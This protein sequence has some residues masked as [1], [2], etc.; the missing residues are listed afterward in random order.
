[1]IVL[2]GGTFDVVKWEVY[3]IKVVSGYMCLW[4]VF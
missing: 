4:L 2:G 1:M 3:A